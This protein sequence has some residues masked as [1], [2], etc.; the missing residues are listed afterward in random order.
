MNQDH[1]NMNTGG[2]Q[3]PGSSEVRLVWYFLRFFFSSWDTNFAWLQSQSQRVQAAQQQQQNNM[4]ATTSATD[5]RV[6]SA[7]VNVALS[8]VAKYWVFTNLFPGPIPQVSVYGLPAGAR[9]ENGK[10]V[11]VSSVLYTKNIVWL[12]R[13]KSHTNRYSFAKGQNV[14]FWSVHK[15]RLQK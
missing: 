9:I 12:Y 4:P 14:I 5:L 8:S 11:Q 6:N 2:G 7:A 15:N 13:T 1:H 10:P 3:P